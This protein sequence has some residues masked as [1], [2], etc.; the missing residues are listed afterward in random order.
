MPKIVTEN[1]SYVYK[2]KKAGDITAL[3]RVSTEFLSDGF[4]CVVGYSG[5]GKTTLLKCIAGLY[6]Y[7]GKIFFDG[8]NVDELTPRDRNIAFVYQEFVLYPHLTV[9]DNIAYPLKLAGADREE[10]VSR[11]NEIAELLEIE[12]CLTRKPKS[13]SCGQQQ[14]TAIARALVKRP[15]VCLL[16]EPLSNIDAQ[17]RIKERRLIKEA[18]KARG[19]TAVYVTHDFIEAISLADKLIVMADGKCVIDGAPL[20]VYD[21]DNE[22]VRYLKGQNDGIV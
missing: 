6:E 7:G 14:R 5:C 2:N 1:L 22:V 15:S 19:C 10:I 17:S 12:H 20:D 4:N 13:I 11:V 3:D 8:N 18:V 21:S 9:F 16:D